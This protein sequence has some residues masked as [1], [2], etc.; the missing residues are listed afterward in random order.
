[1]KKIIIRTCYSLKYRNKEIA[2]SS[3]SVSIKEFLFFQLVSQL[4]ISFGGGGWKGGGGECEKKQN[5]KTTKTR[6]R[7]NC[8]N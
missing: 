5:N 1:M 6:T 8:L 2:H 4:L 7:A 3:L